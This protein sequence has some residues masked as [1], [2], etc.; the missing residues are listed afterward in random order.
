MEAP[1]VD[2]ANKTPFNWEP[3]KKP[4]IIVG[5]VVALVLCGAIGWSLAK[6]MNGNDTDKKETSEVKQE[7]TSADSTLSSSSLADTETDEST[8]N[9]QEVAPVNVPQGFTGNGTYSLSGKIN[10]RYGIVMSLYFNDNNVSGDYYYTSKGS[11]NKIYLSGWFEGGKLSLTSEYETFEL[12][13]DGSKAFSGNWYGN[14]GN[15]MS[16]YVKIR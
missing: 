13:Y 11:R 8:Y 12:Y 5:F 2:V 7:T 16:T 4:L 15:V 6:G 3:Y 1:V 9:E 14:N 10:R